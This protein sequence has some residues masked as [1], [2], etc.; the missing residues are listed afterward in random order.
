MPNYA[1]PGEHSTFDTDTLVSTCIE[2]GAGALLLNAQVIPPTFFD[3]S[4]RVTG[5]L[6]HG[7]SKYSLRLAAVVPDLS[8]RSQSFQDFVRE[9]NRGVQFRFFASREDAIAWLESMERR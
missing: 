2:S 7:L 4:T 5:E 3:L 6:L 9:S 1:E 8:S